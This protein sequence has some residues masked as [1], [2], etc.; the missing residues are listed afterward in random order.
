MRPRS[1]KGCRARWMVAAA[2]LAGLALSALAVADTAP[3]QDEYV[4]RLEAI[5]KPNFEET[6]RAVKGVRSD[7]Q[8]ERF[9]IAARKF[10]NARRIFAQTVGA[11]AAVPR[12]PAD[13]AQLAKWFRYLRLQESYLGGAASALRTRHIV[14][15]Q[16]DSVRV[17]HTGNLANDVVITYGFDYCR[18]NF[19]RFGG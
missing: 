3:S 14:R 19:R 13:T 5:C 8:R 9:T 11:L 4:S 7:I 2:L 15:Y 10:S 17:V 16:H 1:M 18:F 6:Q 12:P